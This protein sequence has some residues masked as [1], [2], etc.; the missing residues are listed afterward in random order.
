[1][2]IYPDRGVVLLR[3]RSCAG[4]FTAVAEGGRPAGRGQYAEEA[5][6]DKQAVAEGE[7]K[8]EGAGGTTVRPGTAS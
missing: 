1:M 2:P 5:P 7:E 6:F 3:S 8:M 4:A